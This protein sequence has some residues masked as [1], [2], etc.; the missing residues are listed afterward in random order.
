MRALP[1]GWPAPSSAAINDDVLISLPD[2]TWLDGAQ[3]VDS[4]SIKR[5]LVGSILPAQVRA[6]SGLSVADGNC[7]FFY[8]AVSGTPWRQGAA[9]ITP[10]GT[11]SLYAQAGALTIPLG[12]FDIDGASATLSTPTMGLALI[13]KRISQRAPNTFPG[14]L[15]ADGTAPVEAAWIVEQLAVSLGYSGALAS[16]DPLGS[17]LTAG[18]LPSELDAWGAI[19]AIVAANLGAAWVDAGGKLIVRDYSWLRGARAIDATLVVDDDLDDLGWATTREDYA[20]RVTV[21][22]YPPDI[23]TRG[24]TT[25]PTVWVADEAY[26]IPA[27]SSID[28]AIDVENVAKNLWAWL[29]QWDVLTDPNVTRMSRWNARPFLDGTGAQPVSTALQFSVRRVNSSRYVITIT[30]TTSGALF[31]VNA[32][33]E[34]S[35]T[36]RANSMA[37]FGTERTI[38]S[39]LADDIAVSALAVDLGPYVQTDTDARRVLNFITSQ[40]LAPKAS[41]S[42]VLVPFDWR[43]ELGDLYQLTH[44][45]TMLDGKV[46]CVAIDLQG[47][48]GDYRQ[49]LD[50]VMLDITLYDVDTAWDA[51]NPTATLASR[52]VVWAG[53]TL[54]DIDLNP[55]KT[56]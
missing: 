10:L 46:L 26:R 1:D 2:A 44:N 41:V 35:L 13:D 42:Q 3:V 39:G 25:D 4:F 56:A 22:Y 24:L 53:K 28:V 50:L 55:L 21:S 34:P 17:T 23:E 7:A 12:T 8:R 27:L 51:A 32:A 54:G 40:T 33:G 6:G 11:A 37:T 16:I 5:D 49:M 47:S 45:G 29:P 48:P 38:S 20:D 36:L 52:D 14:Y 43:R 18:Y 15:S 19:Q 9:K 30:N 31:T